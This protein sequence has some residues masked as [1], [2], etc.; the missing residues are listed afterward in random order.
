MVKWRLVVAARRVFWEALHST[1]GT[2][3]RLRPAGA[4]AAG[5]RLLR[6]MVAGARVFRGGGWRN[7]FVATRVGCW[8]RAAQQWPRAPRAPP[9]ARVPLPRRRAGPA[10]RAPA[11]GAPAPRCSATPSPLARPLQAVRR[12]RR[13][14]HG[15]GGRW[16]DRALAAGQSAASALRRRVS[17][18]AHAAA[19]A[20]AR[21]AAR[22]TGSRQRHGSRP[23]AAP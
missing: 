15:L 18:A 12:R 13:G 9:P 21:R 4:A 19:P 14:L 17:A 22:G 16:F 20:A 3:A 11:Q 6:S 23:S 2:N 8:G 10:T 1:N 7:G 5:A